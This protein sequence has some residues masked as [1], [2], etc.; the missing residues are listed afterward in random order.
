MR[1]LNSGVLR[2]TELGGLLVARTQPLRGWA[3]IALR[4]T[5]RATGRVRRWVQKHKKSFNKWKII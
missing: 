2:P 5:G 3:P 1:L 4:A